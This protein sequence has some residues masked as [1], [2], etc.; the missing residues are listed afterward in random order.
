MALTVRVDQPV[1][2]RG[3]SVWRV[4]VWLMLL[5]SAFGCLQYVRHAQ[6]VW[7][8]LKML[9]PGQDQAVAAMHGMLG[10][11]VAYLVG[12]FALIVICAGCILRQVWARPCMRVAALLLAVWFLLSGIALM[13]QWHSLFSGAAGALLREQLSPALSQQLP[14]AYRSLQ[15]ALLFKGIA[16]PL[17]L[18]LSWRLGKPAVRA[19]FRA[20]R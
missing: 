14:Q 1:R 3:L 16:V 5:F 17:L 19:Q 7:G 20:R 12:A 13:W 2:P 15:L 8:Q 11:D 9:P 10:W 18:W 6:Q 4:M